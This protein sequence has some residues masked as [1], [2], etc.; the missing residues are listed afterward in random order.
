MVTE[1]VSKGPPSRVPGS[2]WL[3]AEVLEMQSR[4]AAITRAQPVGLA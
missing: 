2:A 4:Q 1:A 3:R